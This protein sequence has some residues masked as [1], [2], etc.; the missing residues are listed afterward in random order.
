MSRL[1]IVG[2]AALAAC[3]PPK[4]PFAAISAEWLVGGWVPPGEHCEGDAGVIYEPDGTWT[5][6]GS[7]GTWRIEGS[8]LMTRVT[9][10]WEDEQPPV[11]LEK[12]KT[13][14]QT[15]EVIGPD[16][17]RSTA[18]DR[19]VIELTRCRDAPP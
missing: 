1:L 10:E 7:A 19:S 4:D 18:Q 5:S 17:Y 13:Y 8:K 11:R 3:A 14:V 15:I 12:P 16:G 2:A 6:Y 9:E